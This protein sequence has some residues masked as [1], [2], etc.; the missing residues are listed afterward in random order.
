MLPSSVWCV[1]LLGC[2]F[3]CVTA[4]DD[5][6][7][8]SGS[9]AGI[10]IATVVVTLV[11]AGLAGAFIWYLW[12]Q[13]RG[14]YDDEHSIEKPMSCPPM[15]PDSKQMMV[16]SDYAF[17]N[18]YFKDDETDHVKTD[19][20]EKG[21]SGFHMDNGDITPSQNA[22]A[23]NGT[24]GHHKKSRPFSSLPFHAVFHPSGKKQR[25]TTDDTYI[26]KHLERVTVPLR[27]HDFTGLGFNICGNMRDGIFVKDVL[28]RGPASESGKIKAGDRIVG[29]T[30]SFAGM[31]YEDALTILSYASPYDVKLELEKSPT[32][33]NGTNHVANLPSSSP[34]RLGAS[35]SFRNCGQ[36]GLFHP[37]YRSQS[38]DDLTQ[39]GKE[40]FQKEANSPAVNS[41]LQKDSSSTPKRSQSVE[42]SNGGPKSRPA[43]T[44]KSSDETKSKSSRKSSTSSCDSINKVTSS[45]SQPA[46]NTNATPVVKEESVKKEVKSSR[47]RVE[48]INVKSEAPLLP[49]RHAPPVKP[50]RDGQGSQEKLS[51]D[52]ELSD[53]KPPPAPLLP[54]EQD[55][56]STHPDVPH[57]ANTTN[58]SEQEA[59]GEKHPTA[60]PRKTNGTPA[61]RRAPAPP[62]ANGPVLK[63]TETAADVHRSDEENEAGTKQEES[64]PDPATPNT[65]PPPPPTSQVPGTSSECP[66]DRKEPDDEE[67]DSVSGSPGKRKASSLGDLTTLERRAKG[68]SESILERAVSMDLKQSI[69]GENLNRQKKILR[70]PAFED[71][72]EENGEGDLNGETTEGGLKRW[73]DGLDKVLAGLTNGHVKLEDELTN[74]EAIVISS[75]KTENHETNG[76]IESPDERIEE[77]TTPP[78][79]I[80]TLDLDIN[81]DSSSGSEDNPDTD[82]PIT[83]TPNRKVI[84]LKDFL[85]DDDVSLDDVPYLASAKPDDEEEDVSVTKQTIRTTTSTSLFSPVTISI[86]IIKPDMTNYEKLPSPPPASTHPSMDASWRVTKISTSTS[87]DSGRYPLER[88][89]VQSLYKPIFS[90]KDSEET[91]DETTEKLVNGNDSDVSYTTAQESSMETSTLSVT[92]SSPGNNVTIKTPNNVAGFAKTLIIPGPNEVENL[93]SLAAEPN[94][95]PPQLEPQ[96]K[97][98]E[99]E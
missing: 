41:K 76:H 58:D 61:K 36:R 13:R 52:I 19:A 59:S 69:P 77:T 48:Q 14:E 98:I 11:T 9:V 34:K 31:V 47:F 23:S 4:Q 67:K 43:V 18:P 55:G 72:Y 99:T 49:V 5:M 63:T 65:E 53:D 3:T 46:K 90:S 51:Q 12:K 22:K 84:E 38:I 7:Y 25:A 94:T 50:A 71:D 16:S 2:C 81:L 30:V 70:T 78:K 66:D 15:S 92:M 60:P 29:V 21:E 64:Q 73:D 37:L 28:H 93:L 1:V 17:D 44:V 20:A 88:I 87:E 54:K 32:S 10:V 79:K 57:A 42:A 6:C 95:P 39:I 24:N 8:T 56:P 97:P 68:S 35:T 75:M 80:L 82:K 91:A 27:G 40:G 45:V 83:S 85:K 89:S 33:S 62:P 26:S 74:D 86:P 96:P